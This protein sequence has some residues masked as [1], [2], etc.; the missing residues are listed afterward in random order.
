M[1]DPDGDPLTIDDV[2]AVVQNSWGVNEDFTGYS[3]CDSRWWDAID[4]CEAAGVCLIWSA[5]NEGPGTESLRSPA[6]RATTPTN[7]FSVGATE[8]N[9]PY[10]IAGFSSRGPCGC[11]GE[12]AMKPEVSAPRHRHLQ[13]RARRRLPVPE[14]HL[15][16]R[17]PRGRC[18]GPD[19]AANPDV[20][21]I[22]IKEVLMATAIDL[23]DPGEDNDYGHGFIDAYE[24][25]LAV[26]G[27]FGT[28]EGIITDSGTGLPIAGR[29]PAE[30]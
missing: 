10:T 2:P 23:G 5:G 30:G 24:A 17:P 28:V 20:D 4:A 6:D 3:D 1:A 16:G 29:P 11:G 8:P 21:V 9:A 19:A 18:G 15:H 26:M 27:G 7:C 13:R 12:F 14:R 25:V 22:T